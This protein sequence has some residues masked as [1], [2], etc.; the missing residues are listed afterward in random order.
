MT[1][2]GPRHRKFLPVAHRC[3]LDRFSGL[4]YIAG[5]HWGRLL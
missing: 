4:P 3:H 1:G 5:T 2:A